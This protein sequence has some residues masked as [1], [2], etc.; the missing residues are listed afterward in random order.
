[1]RSNDLAVMR[2]W[3][4]ASWRVRYGEL[5]ECNLRRKGST[6]TTLLRAVIYPS[7]SLH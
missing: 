4:L 3:L 7:L 1:M 5:K 2:H 6:L